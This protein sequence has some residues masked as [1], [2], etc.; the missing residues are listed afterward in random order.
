MCV[1][2]EYRF[3]SSD[4][5]KTE[6]HGVKWTP[7]DGKVRAVLQIC[8]GMQEYIERYQELAEFLT[9]RGFAVVGHDH[10]GHGKTAKDPSELGIMH[11]NQPA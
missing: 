1:K 4:D 11:T 8:H 3:E 2:E 10:I 9:A 6:I 5:A 7:T